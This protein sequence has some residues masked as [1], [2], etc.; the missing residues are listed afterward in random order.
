MAWSNNEVQVK[1]A[2]ADT[3]LVTTGVSETS[4]AVALTVGPWERT[5]VV[6]AVPAS[7][8]A[9][10]VGQVYW[11]E[12][13]DPD[14]DATDEPT[15]QG[16]Y[17]GTIDTAAIGDNVKSFMLATNI[18]SGNLV[19]TAEGSSVSITFSAVITETIYTA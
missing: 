4:D 6:M 9:A 1:W 17:L 8:V 10:Q 14:N 12:N 7:A 11:V 15:T 3:K 2:A 13:T 5:V 16:T 19:V 18:T